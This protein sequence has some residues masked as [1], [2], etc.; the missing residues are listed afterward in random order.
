MHDSL[1]IKSCLSLPCLEFD[2]SSPTPNPSLC[3]FSDFSMQN[4]AVQPATW[5]SIFFVQSTLLHNST[6]QIHRLDQRVN[7]NWTTTMTLAGDNE[8]V[9]FLSASPAKPQVQSKA[10]LLSDSP[11]YEFTR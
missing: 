1:H 8:C 10:Y 6:I 3:T 5:E 2:P 7:L 4:S 9:S 11:I